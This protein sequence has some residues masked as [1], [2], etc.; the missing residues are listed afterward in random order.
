M[1]L[2]AHVDRPA[3]PVFFFGGGDGGGGGQEPGNTGVG[4]VSKA[5]GRR[6]GGKLKTKEAGGGRNQ[7]ELC[8]ILQYFITEEEHS[9][10]DHGPGQ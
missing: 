3:F 9:G 8:H 1:V 7:K 2:V 5:A 4:R 6:V 10:Q